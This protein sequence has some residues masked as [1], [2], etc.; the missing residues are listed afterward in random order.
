[1]SRGQI[2]DSGTNLGTDV[3][4]SHKYY[5]RPL[6]THVPQLIFIKDSTGIS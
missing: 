3:S 2:K 5:L 4:T 6:K 1:M